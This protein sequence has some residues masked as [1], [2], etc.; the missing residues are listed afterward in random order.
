MVTPHLPPESAT[1]PESVREEEAKGVGVLQPQPVR[2][3]YTW[4]QRCLSAGRIVAFNRSVDAS[5][6]PP[7]ISTDILSTRLRPKYLDWKEGDRDRGLLMVKWM[8]DGSYD[9]QGGRTGFADYYVRRMVRPCHRLRSAII[10]ES[11]LDRGRARQDSSK[12]SGFHA[13]I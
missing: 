12:A 7:D 13:P 4:V 2:V 11:C 6:H 9:W 1:E 5:A 3:T 10:A 8:E